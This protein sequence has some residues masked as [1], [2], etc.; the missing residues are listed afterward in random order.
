MKQ[1][2]QS[3]PLGGK[4]KKIYLTKGRLKALDIQLSFDDILYAK[5]QRMHEHFQKMVKKT[6]NPNHVVQV[7]KQDGNVDY[8]MQIT[9]VLQTREGWIVYVK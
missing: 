5:F 4:G 6:M 3:L 7:I 2:N 9:K 8:I 1:P